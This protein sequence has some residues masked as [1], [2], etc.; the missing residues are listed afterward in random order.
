MLRPASLAAVPD[1]ERRV[2]YQDVDEVIGLASE[3]LHADEESLSLEDVEDIGRQ[4]DIPAEYVQQAVQALGERQRLARKA[5]AKR[6]RF[7]HIIWT[8]LAVALLVVGVVSMRAHQSLVS[9]WGDVDQARS[10]VQSVLERRTEVQARLHGEE[11]TSTREAELAGADN[12]VRIEMR[13]YDEAA[14]VYNTRAGAFPGSLWVSLF[15]L[16]PRARL[17]SDVEGW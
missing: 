8:T 5:A 10:Q 9:L 17:A 1:P 12:R 16:P 14:A 7:R 2:D 6:E 3:L 15:G 13:R 4:L 11:L